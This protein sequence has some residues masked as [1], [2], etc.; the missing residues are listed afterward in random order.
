MALISTTVSYRQVAQRS[1]VTRVPFLR[2]GTDQGHLGVVVPVRLGR[3]RL[4]PQER[5]QRE[6]GQRRQEFGQSLDVASRD[7]A[8]D[9][10]VH[11]PDD[12]GDQ[13]L[14]RYQREVD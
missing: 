14:L 13:L 4:R 1:S 6:V 11:A 10:G 3:S 9:V 8:I 2:R 7:V 5:D 12:R